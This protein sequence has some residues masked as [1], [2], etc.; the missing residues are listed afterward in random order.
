VL[1]VQGTV[2]L[3]ALI[4]GASV[5]AE[6][7]EDRTLTYLFTRPVPRARGACSAAGSPRRP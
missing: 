2:P 7:I 3:L 1:L 6:E 5:V 4:L